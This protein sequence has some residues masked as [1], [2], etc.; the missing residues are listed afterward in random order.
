[1]HS[2]I[3]DDAISVYTALLL[4][5]VGLLLGICAGR[6]TQDGGSSHCTHSVSPPWA[7][8]IHLSP[9]L[10]YD[11]RNRNVDCVLGV[12]LLTF[13]IDWVRSGWA[14][15]WDGMYVTVQ[16]LT[17]VLPLHKWSPPPWEPVAP[18]LS[19]GKVVG[20]PAVRTQPSIYWSCIWSSSS[21]LAGYF[22]A[23][24]INRYI[25]V[26]RGQ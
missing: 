24:L 25:I 5:Y 15:M 17:L 6:G 7:L 2:C 13:R 10:L 3:I 16:Y 20:W 18:V 19:S 22:C 4:W 26:I 9:C 14:L 12:P 1:M 8:C 21:S 11:S 23:S